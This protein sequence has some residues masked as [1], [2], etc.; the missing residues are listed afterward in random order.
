M[1]EKEGAMGYGLS[2]LRPPSRPPR[3]PQHGV[4][5]ITLGPVTLP[6]HLG[7]T[8]GSP[9]HPRSQVGL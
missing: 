2:N 9:F 6:L 7:R 1:V 8:A 4:L 3:S 5:S